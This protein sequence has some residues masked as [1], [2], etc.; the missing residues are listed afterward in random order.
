M[1]CFLE[2]MLSHWKGYKCLSIEKDDDPLGQDML[3]VD[4][5]ILF[6]RYC[7]LLRVSGIAVMAPVCSTW[8]WLCRAVMG[9]SAWNPLGDSSRLDV[10]EANKMVS[11]VALLLYLLI[12]KGVIFILEQPQSSCLEDHPRMT[13]II[14]QFCLWRISVKMQ[15]FMGGHVKPLF[16]YTNCESM[17]ELQSCRVNGWE[18]VSVAPLV[19]RS[20]SGAITGLRQDVKLSQAY[21]SE[22]GEA[23]GFVYS[24]HR[25]WWRHHVETGMYLESAEDPVRPVATAEALLTTPLTPDEMWEDAELGQVLAT[26]QRLALE[27]NPDAY[28]EVL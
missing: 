26:L 13:D 1:T 27:Q 11:R 24:K 3:T 8:V 25:R 9:R 2:A 21:S 18:E 4:G 14:S 20:A 28:V 15:W 6:L 22:F 7:L 12:I 16:L 23:I 10:A 19:V 17:S 5:F